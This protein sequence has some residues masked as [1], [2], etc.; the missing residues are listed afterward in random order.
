M[1]RWDRGSRTGRA[2]G[3]GECRQRRK[4]RG[5]DDECLSLHIAFL[6]TAPLARKI[7]KLGPAARIKGGGAL[8]R[9]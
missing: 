8:I 6:R 1:M 4:H 9:R 2:G 7:G 5:D 3:L